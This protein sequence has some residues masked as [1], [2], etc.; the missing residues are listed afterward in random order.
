MYVEE[1]MTLWI[2]PAGYSILL[3]SNISEEIV[4]D[5]RKATMIMPYIGVIY[6]T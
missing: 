4:N 6:S 1:N 5:E 2:K 3:Q